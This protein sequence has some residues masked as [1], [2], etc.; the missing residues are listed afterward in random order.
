M[1]SNSRQFEPPTERQAG[2]TPTARSGGGDRPQGDPEG[3]RRAAPN[4]PSRGASNFR[5]E[6]RIQATERSTPPIRTADRQTRPVR[7]QRRAAAMAV[8]GAQRTVS[9]AS[10]RPRG[11]RPR[12]TTRRCTGLIAGVLAGD[13]AGVRR[14]V[15]N[16]PSRGAND[17]Q[18]QNRFLATSAVQSRLKRAA[19]SEVVFIEYQFRHGVTCAVRRSERS[20]L[21]GL[22]LPAVV[23]ATSGVLRRLRTMSGHLPSRLRRLRR[24]AGGEL[25]RPLNVRGQERV[26]ARLPALAT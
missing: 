16:N 21:N 8:A 23:T 5:P 11:Q 9:R 10:A 3:V 24:S 17:I 25:T 4:N 2:S 22:S 13:P 19:A 15:P 14:A 7:Q 26:Q 12:S 18:P 20:T 1:R 6:N